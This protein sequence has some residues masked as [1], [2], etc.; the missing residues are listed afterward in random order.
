MDKITLFFKQMTLPK[1]LSLILTAIISIFMQ[2]NTMFFGLIILILIDLLTG[3]GKSMKSKKLH[4]PP[5]YD[6]F[7]ITFWKQLE[8]LRKA[9]TSEGFRKTWD[10]T[11]SYLTVIVLLIILEYTVLQGL[12]VELLNK[13]YS[14]VQIGF[15]VASGIEI[16]SI[17]ENIEKLWGISLLTKIITILPESIQ[18]IFENGKHK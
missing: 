6:I 8:A 16:W 2:L 11:K 4:F 17:D 15:I 5:I 14:V 18:K 1:T 13:E 7:K 10:K 9:T 12:V 3:I